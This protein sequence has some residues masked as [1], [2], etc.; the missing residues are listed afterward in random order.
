MHRAGQ[1]SI[2]VDKTI[3]TD[4]EFPLP[5]FHHWCAGKAGNI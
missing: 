1:Q 2:F 3:F 5:D 4:D